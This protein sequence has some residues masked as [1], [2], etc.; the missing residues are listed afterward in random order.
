MLCSY[1]RIFINVYLLHIS[2][3]QLI[4][5]HCNVSSYSICEIVPY[6]YTITRYAIRL[7]WVLHS[8]KITYIARCEVVTTSST[9][10]TLYLGCLFKIDYP[11]L[12][13]EPIR[14]LLKSILDWSFYFFTVRLYWDRK[15][16]ANLNSYISCTNILLKP[17][18]HWLIVYS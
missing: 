11:D 16:Y 6:C 17:G 5:L 2:T 14:T 15:K 12:E 3:R 1:K 8:S 7:L 18:V 13:I 10:H 9:M 4:N